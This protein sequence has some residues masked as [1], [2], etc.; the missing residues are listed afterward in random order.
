VLQLPS[1]SVF[2]ICEQTASSAVCFGGAPRHSAAAGG[3]SGPAAP[4]L[5]TRPPPSPTRRLCPASA[6]ERSERSEPSRLPQHPPAR[7][8]QDN[9]SPGGILCVSASAPLCSLRKAVRPSRR[10]GRWRTCRSSAAPAAPRRH[11]P[12]G[13]RLLRSQGRPGR[14]RCRAGPPPEPDQP[15]DRRR[16]R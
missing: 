5:T 1:P 11:M 13:P 14:R 15:L 12:A 16:R 9:H 7:C 10:R 6:S 8:Q 2:T 3:L 4:G